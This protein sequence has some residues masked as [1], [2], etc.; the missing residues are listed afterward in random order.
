MGEMWAYL[1]VRK[2]WWLMPVLF[3]LGAMAAFILLTGGA[4]G[5]PF[6]YTQF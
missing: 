4:A 1:K 6:I 2:R 5:I 3:V